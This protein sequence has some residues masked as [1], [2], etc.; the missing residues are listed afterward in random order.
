MQQLFI[1]QKRIVSEE[2]IHGNMVYI[3]LRIKVRKYLAYTFWGKF[4]QVYNA[5]LSKILIQQKPELPL[6]L[7]FSVDPLM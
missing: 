4:Q 3:L 1:I 2:I 5:Q 6:S 7:D